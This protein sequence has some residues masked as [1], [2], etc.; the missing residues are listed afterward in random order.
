MKHPLCIPRP[1][2]REEM[3]DLPRA[4]RMIMEI[5]HLLRHRV[6]RDEADGVMSQYTARLLLSHLAV[7]GSASQLELA[8]LLHLAKP[9]VS[10]LLRR[11]ED[12]GYVERCRDEADRRV[13]RV[14]LS[15]KGKQFDK[16]RLARICCNDHTAMQ[17]FSEEEQAQLLSFLERIREN[18]ARE[19]KK[20]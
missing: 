5:S 19:G 20:P 2:E 15:Q 3:R 18:L 9:T 13:M 11:M 1:P 8:E 16:E 6:R 10:I 17:G 7:K 14:T 4:P 12:E